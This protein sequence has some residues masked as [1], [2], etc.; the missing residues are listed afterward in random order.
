MLESEFKL[1]DDFP[2]VSYEQ[3]REVVEKDL[4]GAPFEK[5]LVT[6]TYEG[7]QIQPVYTERDWSGEGDASGFPGAWPFTRGSHVLGNALC[8]WDIRQEHMLPQPVEN[9]KAILNDLARGATSIQLRFDAAG[10]KGLG[11]DDSDFA[12]LAGRDGCMVYGV[13]D[14]DATLN[15]VQ[16]ELAG[17]GLEAGAAFLPA[18]ASAVALYKKRNLSFSRVW[19]AFNADPLAVLVRSGELPAP[20]DVMLS[21]MADLAKWTD[22]NLARFRSI[23]VGT[24]PYHH[25]GA[26][27][28][29][30]LGFSMATGI[31]YLRATQQAGMSIAAGAKQ[32][33]FAYSLG[34]NA[35]LAIA[36]LRAARR[37]WARVLDACGVEFPDGEDPGM[38][39][40]ARTSKRV[41]TARDPWVN[42][43][44]NTVT[45]F[46]GAVGGADIFTAEPFDKAIG[47]SD[48]FSRR[49]ARNTQVILMEESH[50]NRVIDPSGGCW[51]IE[52]L[53]DELC[54][55]GWAVLQEIESQGGMVKAIESKWIHEQIDSAFAPRMKNIARRK[56]ALTGVSEF[57]NLGEK[58]PAR[59]QPDYEKLVDQ[60]R[61]QAGAGNADAAKA[62]GQAD[63]RMAACIEAAGQG[64]SISD[65][66]KVLVGESQRAT[67]DVMFPFPYAKPFEELRDA[68]DDYLALT[69]ERPKVFLAN[70]GPVAHHTV[71]ATYAKNFFEAGGFQ[72]MDNQGF[73]GESKEDT[74]GAAQKAADAF[75]DSGASIAVI[76]SSDVLYPGMVPAVTPKLK[77]AGARTV[78]L[79]GN[80][81]ENKPT[82]DQAG[83]DR[84]IYISC[85]VLG[86]LRELLEEEGV[87]K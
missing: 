79:A 35:F 69:G 22:A 59:R 56:D 34:C 9:N 71:R 36:K 7:I 2:P 80:P 48:D 47:L 83:V 51:F 74:D 16:L 3:W 72:V 60:A 61:A 19:G 87:L 49:I 38:V 4:Q 54:E 44:R 20:V 82:Y 62:I 41:I 78:I 18:A 68:S 42:L 81:G 29:Q 86:T 32:M 46:A 15:A 43:L 66:M 5:K 75:R 31:T 28:A 27:A 8:G 50:L 1:L 30:D 37:L 85:D 21:Q 10:R 24:G 57:P 40:H 25:A 58:A 70:M 45:T 11:P 53:T 55:K 67:T 12:E 39:I 84:Y 17:L 77:Q 33:V 73:V 65:M 23:R 13:P 6:N 76:C 64:A 14:L 26:T 52:E 63:D